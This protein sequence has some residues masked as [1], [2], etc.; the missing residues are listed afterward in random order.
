FRQVDWAVDMK[1]VQDL[2]KALKLFEGFQEGG[3]VSPLQV[4]QVNSTLL[5][6]RNGVLKDIQDKT[7]AL[8]QFKLQLGVPA[9]LPLILD[10]TPAR[11]V[12]RQMDRYYE[13]VTQMEAAAKRI[14]A[15]EVAPPEKLR[16]FLRQLYT[17]DPLVRGTPFQKK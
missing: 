12:T 13:V 6:A 2:E 5:N 8:D 15:Q 16:A 1:Y 14:D 9:N 17:N 7:N 3:Q 4:M 11:P 10:D